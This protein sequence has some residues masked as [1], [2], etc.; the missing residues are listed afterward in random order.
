MTQAIRFKTVTQVMDEG[1]PKEQ[2]EELPG[3]L[4]QKKK[5]GAATT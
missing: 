5:A 2:A 1:Q 3:I 4:I